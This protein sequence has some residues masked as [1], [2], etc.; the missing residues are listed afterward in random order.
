MYRKASNQP[1]VPTGRDVRVSMTDLLVS[2][3]RR[4]LEFDQLTIDPRLF[5][6]LACAP[7]IAEFLEKS[8]A[9]AKRIGVFFVRPLLNIK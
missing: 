6:L 5:K 1:Y 7:G 8:N 9:R 4:F 3:I 2:G